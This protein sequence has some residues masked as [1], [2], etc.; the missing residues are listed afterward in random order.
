MGEKVS[1]EKRPDTI[2]G[3]GAQDFNEVVTFFL[4]Q[5]GVSVEQFGKLYGLAIKGRPYTKA[6]LYQM[7]QNKSFPNDPR[8][9]WVIA[10]LLQIPPLLLGVHALDDLLP[11]PTKMPPERPESRVL[12]HTEVKSVDLRA[13]HQALKKYSNLNHTDTAASSWGKINQRIVHLE[14]D[15]LYNKDQKQ[16]SKV[17][18]LLCG[19]HLLLSYIARD[20]QWYDLATIHCN[21]AYGL[22]SNEKIPDMQAAILQQRGCVL[23]SQACSYENIPDPS[24]ARRYFE[25][26]SADFQK[27]QTFEASL[28]AYPGLQG[29]LHIASGV[30]QAHLATHPSQLHEALKEL[31]KAE[32][33]IG[34]DTSFDI[35]HQCVAFSVN[36]SRYH[37]DR[38]SIYVNTPVKIAR[39]PKDARRELYWATSTQK[40]PNAKRQQTLNT[41]FLAKSYL[42]EA[43]YSEA[44]KRAKEALNLTK[45]IRSNV[46]L[47]RIAAICQEL[48]ESDYGKNH[49]EVPALEIEIAK[50]RY[51]ELFQ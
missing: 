47:A 45:A 35:I 46:N 39:Y 27:A 26:A 22:A 28:S 44:T 1:S 16:G 18:S 19:Y 3:D 51:P 11:S 13:Y 40:N 5:N 17:A 42:I 31:D 38:A 49:I 2:L 9:R 34:Q 6:R 41:I 24:M 30:A 20:Q 10:K 15:L 50:A 12:L 33:F 29:Y 8:R 48:Q 32:R 7:I 21:K 25:L 43:E 4:R 37:L 14:Q 36:E 23:Y